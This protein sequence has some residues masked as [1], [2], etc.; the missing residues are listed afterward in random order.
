[1]KKFKLFVKYHFINNKI[2]FKLSSVFLDVIYEIKIAQKKTK[3][4]Y[5]FPIE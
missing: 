1:M 5:K 4:V 2:S 3:K